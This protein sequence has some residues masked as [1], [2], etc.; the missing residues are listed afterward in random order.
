M[1]AS[2]RVAQG[3]FDAQGRADAAGKLGGQ[4]GVAAEVEEMVIAADTWQTQYLSKELTEE[5][6]LGSAGGL[7]WMSSQPVGSRQ[8]PAIELAIGGQRQ[9]VEDHPAPG[10]MWSGRR[11]DRAARNRAGSGIAPGEATT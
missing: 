6:L 8:G 4:E 9:G 1:G 10:T 5:L 3:E 11:R 2:K 7:V